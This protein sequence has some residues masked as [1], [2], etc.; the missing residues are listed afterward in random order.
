MGCSCQEEPPGNPR[1]KKF[2]FAMLLRM[3]TEK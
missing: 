3:A 1:D 2:F